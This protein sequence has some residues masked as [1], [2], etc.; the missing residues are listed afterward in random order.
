MVNSKK[1]VSF[2]YIQFQK[3]S[4]ACTY[5]YIV[6]NPHIRYN[7]F[8][9][10]RNLLRHTRHIHS[11]ICGC[12]FLVRIIIKIKILKKEKT[13]VYRVQ[14]TVVMRRAL[15]HALFTCWIPGVGG[16]G[17]GNS[18]IKL[19]GLNRRYKRPCLKRA[20]KSKHTHT[21]THIYTHRQYTVPSRTDIRFM[22][23]RRSS[24][25]YF[26]YTHTRAPPTRCPKV[27]GTRSDTPLQTS[28]CV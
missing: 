8:C 5:V 7:V 17:S 18:R 4:D 28:L 6:C 12:D 16:S 2:F 25:L 11:I 1:T 14:C 26:I 13:Y 10:L 22:R 19:H 24:A 9:T 21:H 3:S 27:C 23:N 15:V 20:R